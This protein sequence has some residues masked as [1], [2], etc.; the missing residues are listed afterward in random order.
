[1][2]C[3]REMGCN[4]LGFF[5]KLPLC[6]TSPKDQECKNKFQQKKRNIF[7][8]RLM[9]TELFLLLVILGIWLFSILK[10]LRYSSLPNC[11]VLYRTLLDCFTICTLLRYIVLWASGSCP[12]SSL[13]CTV[14]QGTAFFIIIF[15]ILFHFLSWGQD[16]PARKIEEKNGRISETRRDGKTE[17]WKNGRILWAQLSDV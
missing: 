3:R 5:W 8:W 14:L 10:F 12:F 4:K 6:K 1:M 16:G 2:K 13:S 11:F 9:F 7:Y 17:D 15:G